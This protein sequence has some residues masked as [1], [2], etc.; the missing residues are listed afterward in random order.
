MF[1]KLAPPK[2]YDVPSIEVLELVP[3]QDMFAGSG[4]G[5]YGYAGDS[6]GEDEYYGDL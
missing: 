2:E 3:E 1:K 5:E 4:Y 6:F